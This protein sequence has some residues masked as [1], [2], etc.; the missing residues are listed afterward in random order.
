[1]YHDL[2]EIRSLSQ[3]NTDRH[4][5]VVELLDKNGIV[6]RSQLL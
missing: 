3:F 1:L 2:K 6:K 4:R 5:P